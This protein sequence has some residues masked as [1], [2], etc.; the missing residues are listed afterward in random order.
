M[1]GLLKGLGKFGLNEL[2]NL[3]VYEDEKK[4][5]N[6]KKEEKEAPQ[7]MKEEDYLFDKTYECPVCYQKIKARTVRTGR[8]KLVRTDIYLRPVYENVE[9]LKYEVISCPCCGY[10]VHSRY[11]GGLTAL[12]IKAIRETISVS[13]QSPTE[14]KLTYTYEEALGRYKL[15]LAS[16][17]VRRARASE[18]AYIC[19]KAGWL[20]IS[21]EENLK[22]READKEGSQEY[23]Q[24]LREI[25]ASQDEFLQNAYEGFLTA[26]QTE[27]YPLAGLDE[28]T[29][30]YITAVLAVRF[31]Q[32]ELA[33]RIISSL[34]TSPSTNS[35]MKDRAGEIKQILV[36]K[37]KEK[38]EE[39]K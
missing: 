38:K 16:A 13:F 28:S 25:R 20:L 32:Y 22:A 37:L 3:N 18:K 15:S 21:M 23:E 10:S 5:T 30:E 33:S 17:I 27:G 12:Q 39:K 2:E 6:R 11:F 4:T 14:E 19:L 8:A 7:V 9:P 36:V 24:K 1:L 29:A 26:R 34:L 35:R 31:E